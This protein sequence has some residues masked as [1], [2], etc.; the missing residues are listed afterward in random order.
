RRS[1]ARPVAARRAFPCAATTTSSRRISNR[2]HRLFYRRDPPR[3]IARRFLHPN[4][5]RDDGGSIV[6]RDRAVHRPTSPRQ[7][8]AVETTCL[9]SRVPAPLPCLAAA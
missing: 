9:Q 2:L 6:A 8:R 4:P 5:V 7:T 1:P 3:E